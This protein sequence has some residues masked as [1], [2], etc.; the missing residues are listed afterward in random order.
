MCRRSEEKKKTKR[1]GTVL[2]DREN[3]LFKSEKSEQIFYLKNTPGLRLHNE[4]DHS[5][6]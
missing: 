5:I 6:S 4:L 1:N 2:N 3:I